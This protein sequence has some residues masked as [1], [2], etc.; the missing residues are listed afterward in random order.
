M[1]E[2]ID[3]PAIIKLKKKSTGEIKIIN[4]Q[5]NSTIADLLNTYM[6][7]QDDMMENTKAHNPEDIYS[8]IKRFKALLDENIISPEEFEQKKKE[9]LNI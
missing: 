7:Q 5:C 4:F 8:E 2:E 1:K 3:T 9:L 6:P